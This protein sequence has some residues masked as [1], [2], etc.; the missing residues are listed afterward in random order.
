[1]VSTFVSLV[2]KNTRCA[3]LQRPWLES[4]ALGS[5]TVTVLPDFVPATLAHV[6]SACRMSRRTEERPE[7]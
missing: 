3:S 6:P 5:V 1:M 2:L 7:V 4:A